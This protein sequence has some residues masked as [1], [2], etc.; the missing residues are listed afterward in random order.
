MVSNNLRGKG[1]PLQEKN[2]LY[3]ESN[4]QQRPNRNVRNNVLSENEDNRL[5]SM[6]IN[7]L[8]LETQL[9]D[10]EGLRSKTNLTMALFCFKQFSKAGSVHHLYGEQREKANGSSQLQWNIHGA[11]LSKPLSLLSMCPPLDFFY[12]TSC[13]PFFSLFLPFLFLSIYPPL[14]LISFLKGYLLL[15]IQKPL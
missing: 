12:L 15:E 5:E 14:L 1:Q 13:P 2:Q 8:L 4:F 6:L 3:E 10:G 7:Q 9:V 11:I